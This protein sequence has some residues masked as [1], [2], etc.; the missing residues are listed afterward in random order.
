MRS[1]SLHIIAA[2]SSGYPPIPE[3][4]RSKALALGHSLAGIAGSNT[5][6]K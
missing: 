5:A 6:G 3:A 2:D 1:C 4:A